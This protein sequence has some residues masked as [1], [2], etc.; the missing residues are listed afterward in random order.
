MAGQPKR[1]WLQEHRAVIIR[2]GIIN[3][4][5]LVIVAPLVWVLMMSIK[6]RADAMRPDFWPRSFDFRSYSYVFE[7]IDTLPHNLFNSIYVTAGTVLFT[8]TFAVLAG[9]ALVHMGPRG[10]G[11]VIAALL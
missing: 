5:M 4:F 1:G 3:F 7:K 6:S 2:H 10:T 9:Y 11:I 8:N